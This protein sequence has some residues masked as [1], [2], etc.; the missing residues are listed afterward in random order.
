M[1]IRIL[2]IFLLLCLLLAGTAFAMPAEEH[3]RDNAGVLSRE[4]LAQLGELLAEI[5]HEHGISVI[6]VTTR[7]VNSTIENYAEEEFCRGNVTDDGIILT[8][9]FSNA[10]NQ[11][12]F[13]AKNAC[14]D[15][16]QPKGF[17][18]LEEICVP[19]L[20]QGDYAGAIEAFALT[21]EDLFLNPPMVEPTKALTV[22]RILLCIAIGVILSFAGPMSIL[23][24]QLRSVRQQTG[25]SEYIRRNSLIVSKSTDRF[26]Y[27]NVSKSARA[28]S[29]PG[30][31]G[32]GGGGSRS[33][34]R[35]GSF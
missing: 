12:Y 17:D 18:R 13:F 30:R 23:K 28:Q 19:M 9:L 5:S 14:Y 34:G 10:G 16:M 35:G 1:R 3:V 4:D 8:L 29:S 11:Y 24:A 21:T 6:A 32:G 22:P 27:R 20:K 7:S 31:S 15:I 25:A 33:G 26:L 2:C